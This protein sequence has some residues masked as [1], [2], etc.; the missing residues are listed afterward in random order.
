MP[1]GAKDKARGAEALDYVKTQQ[2]AEADLAK[3]TAAAKSQL[4]SM[5]HLR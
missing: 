5:K 3:K 4:K 2:Q 1:S